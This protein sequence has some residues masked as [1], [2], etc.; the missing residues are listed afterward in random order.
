MSRTD[1]DDVIRM[2]AEEEREV[3]SDLRQTFLSGLVLTV[4]FL[5]TVLVLMWALNAVTNALA[6]L[7]DA[8]LMLGPFDELGRLL[9][10]AMAA[11]LV[12]GLILF[13]GLAAKHGPETHVGD[14]FDALM[15][16]LPGIGSIYSSVDRMSDVLVEG[17]TESFQEV[18][19]VEYPHEESYAIAFLTADTPG[20]I[21]TAAGHDDMMTV[22]VPMAPNPVMGGNLV[23][24][25]ADRVHDVDLSVEEGMEAIMSTG[26]TLDEAARE[27][28]ESADGA[29]TDGET[30]GEAA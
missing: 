14:R 26:L 12:L 8:I 9:V 29:R 23:S 7:A 27:E 28:A 11:G 16:D 3:A 30:S 19:L 17:D 25:S 6:P 24:M 20:V 2:A 22:F 21:Q 18:K 5:I 15:E 13:V 10:E 4:P 1:V